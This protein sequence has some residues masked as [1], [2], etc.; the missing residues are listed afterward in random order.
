MDKAKIVHKA[1]NTVEV[2]TSIEVHP[3]CRIWASLFFLQIQVLA[4]N[5]LSY[6]RSGL[7]LKYVYVFQKARK[8][9]ICYDCTSYATTTSENA[10]GGFL[11]SQDLLVLIVL[12]DRDSTCN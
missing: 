8:N 7:D 4:S 6:L 12:N 9:C 11:K 5:H 10:E 3:H 2:C 1:L